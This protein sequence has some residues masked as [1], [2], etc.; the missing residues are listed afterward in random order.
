MDYLASNHIGVYFVIFF[1]KIVEVT[2]ATLR[3]VLISRGERTKGALVA[4]VE[5]ILWLMITGTV[6]VGFMDA[7][8]KILVF[9][10]AFAIGNYLGS[11]LENKIA[12]GLSTIQ[13]ITSED[14]TELLD[15]LRKNYLAVTVIDAEGKDGERKVLEIHLKRNRIPSTVKLINKTIKNC[16]ITVRDVKVIKGGYIKK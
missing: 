3:I 10:L 5:V 4:F 8:I 7:P 15:V 14:S 6:L 13:I 11:W 16:V 12:V 1:G 2:F 9:A